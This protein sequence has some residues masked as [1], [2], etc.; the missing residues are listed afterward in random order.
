MGGNTRPQ[1]VGL[2]LTIITVTGLF[3]LLGAGVAA[4]GHG[5]QAHAGSTGNCDDRSGQGGGFEVGTDGNGNFYE[6]S[7][8]DVTGSIAGIQTLLT[9]SASEQYPSCGE[10][11][12]SSEHTGGDYD[13]L[14]IYVHSGEGAGVQACYSEDNQEQPTQMVSANENEDACG[15]NFE[16]PEDR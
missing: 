12:Q 6:F 2:A 5:D 3:L 13:H 10:D 9:Y 8:E 11:Q 16:R 14:D 1:I 4:A 15:N 7:D